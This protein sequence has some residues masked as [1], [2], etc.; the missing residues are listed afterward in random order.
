MALV[1]KT[2]VSKDTKG[3]NPFHFNYLKNMIY[4]ETILK[5]GE[6]SGVIWSKCINIIKC[7]NKQVARLGDKVLISIFRSNSKKKI[8]NKKYIGL[9]ISVK[10][11][12]K[13]FDGSFIKFFKNRILLL[14]ENSIFKKET[15]DT[16]DTGRSRTNRKKI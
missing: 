14:S 12:T 6:N 5:N 7:G 1:L 9:I 4:K 10:N 15:K 11:F 16:N 3:S 2:S 13:R 8:K